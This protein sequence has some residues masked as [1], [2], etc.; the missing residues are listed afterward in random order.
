VPFARHAF[1]LWPQNPNTLRATQLLAH[2]VLTASLCVP[3]TPLPIAW[4]P[5]RRSAVTNERLE[6][7]KSLGHDSV[8]SDL[9]PEDHYKIDVCA[10]RYDLLC[11]EGLTRALSIYYGH[12]KNPVYKTVKPAK[13][14]RMVVEPACAQIRPYVVCAILRNISFDA[15]G[16]KSFID[17][18]EKLHFNICRRRTLVAIGTHDDDKVQGPF[19]YKAL[20]PKDIKFKP[21]NQD[22]EMDAEE[23]MHFYET[24]PKGAA[25]KEYVK[26]IKDSPVY[27]VIYDA[28]G[29]VLSLPPIINGDHSKI[30]LGTKNVFI[31]CTATDLTKARTTLN[32]VVCMFS[33]HCKEQYEVEQV[34]VTGVSVGPEA[35]YITPVLDMR[36]MPPISCDYIRSLVGSPLDNPSICAL[37]ERMQLEAKQGPGE[38]EIS[39]LVPPTRSDIFHACDVAEDVAIAYVVAYSGHIYIY[40]GHRVRSIVCSVWTQSLRVVCRL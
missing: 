30:E 37:L 34:E 6:Q 26:I 13:M 2:S 17:L 8:S 21:L 38:N 18:Q 5:R 31:E 32:T 20:P 29:K 28:N 22:R 35:T 11:L 9:S 36:P 12:M 14:E 27:P 16:Y 25:I 24:D 39:V 40:S 1:L 15:K 7:I 3:R 33:Q 4:P 23:M 19:T 10:N